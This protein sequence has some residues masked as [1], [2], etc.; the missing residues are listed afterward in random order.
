[1]NERMPPEGQPEPQEGPSSEPETTASGPIG[2][3]ERPA[4]ADAPTEPAP[5]TASEPSPVAA[6]PPPPAAAPAPPP[7]Q[8]AVQWQ[9]PA[10]AAAAVGARAPRTTLSAIGGVVLLVL[11][12]LGMLFGVLFLASAALVSQLAGDF[13]GDIPEV[14]DGVTAGG[15][16]GGVI[17][18]FAVLVLAY[19]VAYVLGGIGVLRS[20]EWGRWLGIIVSVISGL[21]WAGGLSGGSDSIAF[22][23]VMFL[24]HLYVFFVLVFRW[25]QPGPPVATMPPA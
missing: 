5:P 25:R 2:W 22:A 1:M 23:L 6:P 14:T 21:I 12:I 24:I 10:P 15:I 4:G 17:A 11:G 18:F 9:A 3:P 16:V 7:A 13:I 19:S 8:P 20:S